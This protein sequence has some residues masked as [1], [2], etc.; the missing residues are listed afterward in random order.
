MQGGLGQLEDVL[1][2]L[3]IIM[4]LKHMRWPFGR[5]LPCRRAPRATSDKRKITAT[6]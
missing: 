5:L 6:Q 1:I 2:S 4:L 3:V